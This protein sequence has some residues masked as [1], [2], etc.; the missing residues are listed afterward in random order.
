MPGRTGQ[1]T[2]SP[3]LR[4][5]ARAAGDVLEAFGRAQDAIIEV[6]NSTAEMIEKAGSAAANRTRPAG[7]FTRPALPA[8]LPQRPTLSMVA[9]PREPVPHLRIL[10]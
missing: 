3:A 5:A 1:G 9:E 8:E 7:L 4:R 6:A 10:R 2:Q